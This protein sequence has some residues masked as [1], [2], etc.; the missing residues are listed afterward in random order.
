MKRRFFLDPGEGPDTRPLKPDVADL[1]P[2]IAALEWLS[3]AC[4]REMVG[5]EWPEFL[6]GELLDEFRDPIRLIRA[7]AEVVPASGRWE[8]PPPRIMVRFTPSPA[9][10]RAYVEA[11]VRDQKALLEDCSRLDSRHRTSLDE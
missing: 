11:R 10:A 8:W 5:E 6:T 2:L 9:L 7:S 3:G 1:R 4:S